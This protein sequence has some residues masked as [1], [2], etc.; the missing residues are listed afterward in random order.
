MMGPESGG[1]APIDVDDPDVAGPAES[2][3]A[4]LAGPDAIMPPL[5]PAAPTPPAAADAEVRQTPEEMKIDQLDQLIE[6][7]YNAATNNQLESLNKYR[8]KSTGEQFKQTMRESAGRFVRKA[9]VGGGVGAMLGGIVGLAG[10]IAGAIGSEAGVLGVKALRHITKGFGG[11]ERQDEDLDLLETAEQ[12][13]ISHLADIAYR[14]FTQPDSAEKDKL[15]LEFLDYSQQMADPK[16]DLNA[17]TA[18]LEKEMKGVEAGWKFGEGAM[19]FIGSILTGGAVVHALREHLQKQALEKGTTIITEKGVGNIANYDK[20]LKGMQHL[21]HH[22]FQAPD[23]A[24]NFHFQPGEV[25]ALKNAL[26]HVP[27]GGTIT[28]LAGNAHAVGNAATEQLFREKINHLVFLKSTLITDAI[29][30]A[31]LAGDVLA[32]KIKNPF[33]RKNLTEQTADMAKQTDLNELGINPATPESGPV[34]GSIWVLNVLGGGAEISLSDGSTVQLRTGCRVEVTANTGGDIYIKIIDNDVNGDPVQTGAILSQPDFENLFAPETPPPPA[35][36]PTPASPALTPASAGPTPPAPLPPSAPV[37]DDDFA[38]DHLDPSP[39]TAPLGPEPEPEPGDNDLLD[40]DFSWLTQPPLPSGGSHPTEE[41]ATDP[42]L[43]SESEEP[44]LSEPAISPE[45][46]ALLAELEELFSKE[47]FEITTGEDGAAK[48]SWSSDSEF[49][50]KIEPRLLTITLGPDHFR[51]PPN[52][53]MS[54]N[55]VPG[56][57]KFKK[58]GNLEAETEI[59]GYQPAQSLI[60]KGFKQSGSFNTGSNPFDRDLFSNTTDDPTK[61]V[62][63]RSSQ[64]QFFLVERELFGEYKVW[65]IDFDENGRISNKT[66]ERTVDSAILFQNRGF[67]GSATTESATD[68]YVRDKPADQPPKEVDEKSDEVEEGLGDQEEENSGPENGKNEEN[69]LEL[70]NTRYPVAELRKL[71]WPSVLIDDA[72]DEEVKAQRSR[73]MSKLF[74]ESP[75]HNS[76]TEDVMGGLLAAALREQRWVGVST[77]SLNTNGCDRM[78]SLGYAMIDE[79]DSKNKMLVPTQKFT[80]FAQERL[81][82]RF[83]LYKPNPTEQSVVDMAEQRPSLEENG[84]EILTDELSSPNA[85]ILKIGSHWSDTVVVEPSQEYTAIDSEGGEHFCRI[86]RINFGGPEPR[87]VFENRDGDTVGEPLSLAQMRELILQPQN[88]I[89]AP[90]LEE[91]ESRRRSGDEDNQSESVRI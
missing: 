80:S 85:L 4:G 90:S 56:T 72:A 32:R 12:K 61:E 18:A 33:R 91:Y 14:C 53:I 24:I 68:W 25:D 5:A 70:L 86:R 63:I 28:E 22:V 26:L 48:F 76:E 87:V 38:L 65:N 3:G 52:C 59:S 57:L 45:D 17:P 84:Y 20:T 21:G 30:L 79:S 37:P 58:D 50:Q 47:T 71:V 81:L 41:E 13:K 8:K 9:L 19:S 43:G 66:G 82:S 35:P 1:H 6:K 73:Y 34:V 40:D 23:G 29:G 60:D 44:P 54:T 49:R 78:V 51:M 16:S 7:F 74:S 39:A 62:V 77:K 2:T 11:K 89:A 10:G 31:T 42:P 15:R 36:A 69:T 64:N 46:E 83:N 67:F 75:A 55:P 27:G 88:R